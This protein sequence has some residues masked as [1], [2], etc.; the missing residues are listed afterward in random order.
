MIS[1]MRKFMISAAIF[2]A[3]VF[4]EA[5]DY[6]SGQIYFYGADFSEVRVLGAYESEDYF[7][8]AFIGINTLFSIESDKYNVSRIFGKTVQQSVDVMVQQSRNADFSKIKVNRLE[9]SSRPSEEMIASYELPHK[10]GIGVVMIARLLDK[11]EGLGTYDFVVFDIA[12]RKVIEEVRATGEA[13]G[14]GLRNYWASSAY[15]IMSDKKLL[16]R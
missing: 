2:F 4:S 14:S 8:K 11:N 12:T 15:E 9:I 3:A 10:D 5:R 13:G 6:G 16:S 1:V 7:T